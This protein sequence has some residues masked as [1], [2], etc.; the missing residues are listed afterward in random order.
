MALNAPIITQAPLLDLKLSY[1]WNF[2]YNLDGFKSSFSCLSKDGETKSSRW[3]G[4]ETLSTSA[5]CFSDIE[6]EI[7]L[8][9]F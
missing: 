9:F 1:Q 2:K 3:K 5:I 8:L 4:P 7:W 6:A